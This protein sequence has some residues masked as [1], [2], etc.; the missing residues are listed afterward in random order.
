MKIII[1]L[2][3]RRLIVFVQYPDFSLTVRTAIEGTD[4]GCDVGERIFTKVKKDC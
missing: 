4:E 3:L 2:H 1:S